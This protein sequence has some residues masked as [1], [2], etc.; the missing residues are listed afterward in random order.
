MTSDASCSGLILVPIA[1]PLC[2]LGMKLSAVS[3]EAHLV[4][5]LDI[6]DPVTQ[7]HPVLL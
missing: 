4:D 1:S 6:V 2:K 7:L 5:G 3:F